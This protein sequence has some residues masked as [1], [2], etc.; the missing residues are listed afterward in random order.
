MSLGISE[1]IARRSVERCPERIS[2]R[3]QEKH[4]EEASTH[5][6]C[7]PS[8]RQIREHGLQQRV[9]QKSE[10]KR[11]KKMSGRALRDLAPAPEDLP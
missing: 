4:S 8:E 5:M 9:R 7:K 10:M 6:H 3:R 11:R 1:W 2:G